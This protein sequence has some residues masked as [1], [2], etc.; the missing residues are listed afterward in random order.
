[1]VCSVLCDVSI[2]VYFV[3]VLC[4][5]LFYSKVLCALCVTLYVC[6]VVCCVMCCVSRVFVLCVGLCVVCGYVFWFPLCCV[7]CIVYSVLSHSMFLFSVVL[8]LA[9]FDNVC[10]EFYF[11]WIR[12]FC[13]VVV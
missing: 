13:F 4:C 5:F 9:L 8:C 12:V 3:C 11:I 6:C 10:F 2:C 1:M 7:Q